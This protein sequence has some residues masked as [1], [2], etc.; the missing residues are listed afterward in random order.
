M[1]CRRPFKHWTHRWPLNTGLFKRS[2]IHT[3]CQLAKLYQVRK[4]IEDA[5]WISQLPVQAR[6]SRS[7]PKRDP[8]AVGNYSVSRCRSLF[9]LPLHL[10][11]GP[12]FQHAPIIALLHVSS[13]LTYIQVVVLV[14]LY[15]RTPSQQS[16][17][18][19]PFSGVGGARASQGMLPGE[20]TAAIRSRAHLG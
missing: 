12:H 9:S 7:H 18:V 11:S 15:C 20:S 14:D 2:N 6:K 13:L 10:L 4:E 19:A 8:A 16:G 1:S 3:V 17:P 5:T